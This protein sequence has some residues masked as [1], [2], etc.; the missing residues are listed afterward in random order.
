MELGLTAQFAAQRAIQRLLRLLGDPVSD[1]QHPSRRDDPY[2]VLQ[3]MRDRG[4]LWKSMSGAWVATTYDVCETLLRDR[5]IGVR[6]ADGRPPYE[7]NIGVQPPWTNTFLEMDPPDHTRLRRLVTPAFSR[8]RMPAY[9]ER[10]GVVVDELIDELET[11]REF[12]LIERFAGPLP[13]T[14]IRE[15]LG[16]PDGDDAAFAHYGKVVGAAV[17]LNSAADVPEIRAVSHALRKLFAEL[18]EERS[19]NPGDDV[20]STLVTALDA[21]RITPEELVTTAGLLLLAGFETTVNLLGNGVQLLL[22]HPEQWAMLRADPDLA[23]RVVEETLRFETPFQFGVRFTHEP[24]TVADVDLPADAPVLIMFG[25]ANR[26]PEVF[27]DPDAFDIYRDA[28]KEHL[29][30]ATGPHYCLGAP[31]AR[32]EGD[33]AF[34]ALAT[35][36]PTLH[37]TGPAKP[38]PSSLVRGFLTLPLAV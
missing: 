30:F 11:A 3:R 22:D 31:L 10:I 26:D 20:I 25:L 35:R 37:R 32:M 13:I 4:P 24:I 27:P 16:V 7:M 38:R 33:L 5:R 1:F 21:E 9:E 23:P 2:P 29:A 34:R 12:D 14:V 8:G 19:K 28:P 17:D 18:I 6:H 15:L 36:L